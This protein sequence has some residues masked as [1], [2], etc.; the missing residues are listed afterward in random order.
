[1]KTLTKI[2]L[3]GAVMA[4]SLPGN[5]AAQRSGVEMWSQ[6]CGNCHRIQPADRYTADQWVTILGQMS[7]QA[8]LTDEEEASILA[9][10]QSGAKKVAVAEPVRSEGT[11]VASTDPAFVPDVQPMD[12]KDVYAK[13]CVACHGKGGKG[14]GPAA[15]AFNPR[16]VDFT[17]ADL[18]GSK[19]DEELLEILKNGRNGMPGFA[20]ILSP[21]EIDAVLAYVRSLS[22]EE[23]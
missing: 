5:L 7:V 17:D 3:A 6:T 15:A 21:E 20:A 12:G 8:R 4:I 14:D 16:P 10:L 19:A 18:M 23:K 1:M 22:A 13:Q 9:F 2:L 11:L